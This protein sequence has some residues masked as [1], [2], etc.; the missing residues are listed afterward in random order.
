M[1][2]YV[3]ESLTDWKEEIL[4]QKIEIDEVNENVKRDLQLYSI[5]FNNTKQ[6]IQ[7]TIS[8]LTRSKQAI[9]VHMKKNFRI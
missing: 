4:E 1:Q 6:V 5:K 3:E 9:I 8:L 7:S 2:S